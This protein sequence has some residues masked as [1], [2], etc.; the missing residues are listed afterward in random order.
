MD[1]PAASSAARLIRKPLDS[2]SSDFDIAPS[3]TD[4]FR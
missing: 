2:F 3:L 1:R 4:R